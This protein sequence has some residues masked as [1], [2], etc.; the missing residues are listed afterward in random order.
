MIDILTIA[1]F[2]IN[3]FITCSIIFFAYRLIKKT[4]KKWVY[5]ASYEASYQ[6]LEKFEKYQKEQRMMDRV[7]EIRRKY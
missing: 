7:N 5:D 4:A 1:T 3:V 6:A 2:V